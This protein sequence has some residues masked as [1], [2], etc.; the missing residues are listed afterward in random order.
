VTFKNGSATLGTGTVSGGKATY[1][2][3]ALTVATHSITAVYAGDSNYGGST[4]AALSQVVDKANTSTAVVS[5]G[6]PSDFGETITFTATVKAVAPG[7]GTPTG[8]VKFMDGATT[9]GSGALSGGVAHYATSN[10]TVGTHS[11]TAVYVA[12]TDYNTSTSA[13]L[14]QVVDKTSTTTTVVSSLNPSTSGATVT[15]TATVKAVAPGAGTPTGTVNFMDGAT[16]IGSH[17]LAGGV[18]AFATSTLSVASHNITAV[19]VASTDYN[20]STSAVLVQVV[21]P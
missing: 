19:Y 6:S 9:M 2:T 5:S 16:K 20:T 15:F 3:S 1:A 11:I 13:V 14:S 12:S 4:S 21:N 7:T 18:A 8:T 17:A 10:R